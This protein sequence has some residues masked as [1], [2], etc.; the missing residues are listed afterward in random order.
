MYFANQSTQLISLPQLNLPRVFVLTTGSSCS[1]TESIINSLSPF[2]Q[3]ITI[4]GTTC[5][6]PYGFIQQDNCDTSY[7]A[8]QFDG[9]NAAGTGSYTN[10]FAPACSVADDLDHALGDRSERLLAGK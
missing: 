9:V 1:A 7:F 5:G 10:G 6:K 4:G 8:I 3:V 2:M